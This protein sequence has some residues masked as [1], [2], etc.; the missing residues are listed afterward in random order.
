MPGKLGE[1]YPEMDA[2]GNW[3]KKNKVPFSG[4]F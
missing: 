1:D 3:P 2:F 4:T